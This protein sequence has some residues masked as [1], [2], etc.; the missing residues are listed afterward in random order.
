MGICPVALLLAFT[1][2]GFAAY[3]STILPSTSAEEQ[4][5]VRTRRA[6]GLLAQRRY[7]DAYNCV[8]INPLPIGPNDAYLEAEWLAGFLALSKLNR[9]E[10]A[11]GHF[12]NVLAI[13]NSLGWQA[14]A[15][16]WMGLAFRRLGLHNES[17]LCWQTASDASTV[18]YGQMSQIVLKRTLGKWPLRVEQREDF[19]TASGYDPFR[20]LSLL[21][22]DGLPLLSSSAFHNKKTTEDLQQRYEGLPDYDSKKALLESLCFL[23]PFFRV[24]LYKRWFRDFQIPSYLGYPRLQEV[25]PQELMQV[26][27]EIL[28][29]NSLNYPFLI[30]FLLTLVHAI[31]RCES[32][33][34]NYARSPAGAC[35]LM[36]LMAP[37]ARETQKDL[38]KKHILGPKD[39][40]DFRQAF[41]N[42][43]LGAAHL[44]QL[45]E[46]YEH[47]I[48]FI[49]AAYNAGQ[50]R[51]EKWLQVY[52]DPRKGETTLL[53]WVESIP[54]RETRF[55][56]QSVWETF[57]V[58]SSLLGTNFLQERLWDLFQ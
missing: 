46:L 11:L 22:T 26:L 43:V 50:H 54:F 21:F 48:V 24:R 25:I 9:P 19:L 30:D 12:K 53:E 18:F 13:A 7:S 16:F 55:Y 45:I 10:E 17:L 51:V 34:N 8:L 44:K 40:V 2:G 33:F 3:S 32:E 28:S 42:L 38:E 5:A 35:G 49:A 31:I 52:G 29:K 1:G 41:D 37:T 56:V 23:H 6:R 4:T 14:K 15:A 20:V 27:L 58:Y 47:N 39:S 57:V 36:Q